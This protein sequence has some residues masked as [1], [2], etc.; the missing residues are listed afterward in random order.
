MEISTSEINNDK[1][2]KNWI[3]EG[4]DNEAIIANYKK[5]GYQEEQLLQLSALIKKIRNKK[6]TQTGS[7]LVLIGVLIL[8]LGFISCIVLHY[9][10]N[11]INFSLFG[12]T[13][14]GAMTLIIGL[15]L[16]FS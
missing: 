14:I 10:G 7:I 13:G 16:L 1:Q 12:L 15:I 11:D 9:C 4:L 8:G 6:R 3:E 5:M 2:L